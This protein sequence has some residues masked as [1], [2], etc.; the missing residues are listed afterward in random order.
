MPTTVSSGHQPDDEDSD[1]GLMATVRQGHVKQSTCDER[2]YTPPA[3][4]QKGS[5]R[6]HDPDIKSSGVGNDP[7]GKKRAPLPLATDGAEPSH[8]RQNKLDAGESSG[9]ESSKNTQ[10]HNKELDEGTGLLKG[11]I[12]LDDNDNQ[13]QRSFLNHL[14]FMTFHNRIFV[15]FVFDE[16]SKGMLVTI[17]KEL[18][19]YFQ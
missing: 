12:T 3:S 5:P 4:P 11:N 18:G 6:K 10:A 19:E 2:D 17:E 13:V 9:D 8:N 1:D 15:V 16:I 14:I 7:I